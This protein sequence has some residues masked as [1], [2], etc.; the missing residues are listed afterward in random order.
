MDKFLL[1]GPCKV[2]GKIDVSGSKNA[3]L[4]ILAATLL[5]D[6][7][8]ELKN[9][10]NVRDVQTMLALLKSLGSKIVI[11]RNK[12]SVKIYNFK[13]M[14]TFASYNLVKTMRAGILV[15]GPLLSKHYKSITSLPGGCSLGTRP[16]NY[17]L[18][19]LAK[20]GAKHKIINGYVHA[21]ANK[22]LVGGKIKFSKV[23]VGAS[24]NL[25]IAATLAKGRSILKNCATEPE[26]KDL[27]N[28]LNS[29]GGKIKWIGKR[30]LQI[31]GVKFLNSIN[32]SIMGDRIETGTWLIAAALTEG[33]LRIRKFNP[34]LIQT[35]INI[36]KKM[37]TRIE[38]KK[39]EIYVQ[40]SKNIKNINLK[41]EV[42]P[43]FPTDLQALMMV[44]L[45]KARGKSEISETIFENRY[46]H[47]AELRRLGAKIKIKGNK[48]IIQG[49]TKFEGAELMSTDLR[50]SA[51]LV[52]AAISAKGKSIINRIY[53]LDRGYEQIEKKLIKVGVKIK[54][55]S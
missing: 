7:P 55:V 20:L 21:T 54:R 35:E 2:E 43:G 44:L 48:S 26:I 4:P 42:Y 37:G 31:D 51:S 11:S 13:K 30:T 41:T 27:I 49:N 10:P 22:G 28:F 16:I 6:K 34:K 18:N 40:G 23:S 5:F 50:A 9:L 52:L 19:G 12:K 29:A 33:K 38:T 46:M 15:L 45:C 53:H 39:D 3:A 32:Y 1:T 14:K 17:H 47:V 25:I 8:V 24:E 36:L